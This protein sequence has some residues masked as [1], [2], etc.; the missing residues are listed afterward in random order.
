MPESTIFKI[1]QLVTPM[2]R[3]F[4][5]DYLSTVKRYNDKRRC[6]HFDNGSRCNEFISAHS[7]Q[8]KGQ[9]QLIAEDGHIYRLSADF[10][11]LDKSGGIP[12][13]KKVGIGKASTFVGFCK[14]HDNALFEPID[15]E[16]LKANKQQVALYAYRSLCREYFVKDN[17][18][19]ALQELKNHKDLDSDEQSYLAASLIG[20][21]L[22]FDELKNHKTNYDSALMRL[23]FD[24]FEFV[25]FKSTSRCPLQLS[26]LSYLDYDF[27]GQDLRDL[28]N[29]NSAQGLITFFT[30]PTDT[31]WAFGFAWHISSGP[32]CR[33]LIRSLK[34]RLSGGAK[35]EDML[36]RFSLSC[37]E[38]H[39]MR[40][41]WWDALSAQSKKSA[42]NR[43]SLMAHPSA[44]V[45]ANYL[46]IGCDGIANWR[47]DSAFSSQ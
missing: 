25:Y 20:H 18:V 14:N 41:S 27:L 30:A 29:G 24:E 21:T 40:I 47:F 9:L 38:N 39:A 46:A 22:G 32:S 26:G 28:N 6:L 43:M 37:C 11:T 45:P 36:L 5:H 31:G 42:L 44:P 19:K 16:F 13:P 12:L 2:A 4:I 7:I 35:L 15:N 17:A 1:K 3:S 34:V 10:A 33:S 23:C 8:K